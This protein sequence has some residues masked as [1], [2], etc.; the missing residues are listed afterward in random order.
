MSDTM[1]TF[2]DSYYVGAYWGPRKESPKECA[3]RTATFLNLLAQSDPF[4]SRWYKPTRSK[5]DAHQHPIMPPDLATLTE[6]FRSGVNREKGGPVF[7]DLGFS[8]WFGNG[9]TGA[10]SA[11][12]RIK[13]GDY[14]GATPN[15]C[16]LKL[17]RKGHNAD[18]LLTAPM[19]AA[20]LRMMEAAWAPDWAVATSTNFRDVL[21]EDG[22]TGTFVGW[23]TYL[24][25]HRGT[26]PPLPAP[27]R[28]EPVE[29]RG[30]LVILTPAHLT[31]SDP[32]HIAL[33]RRVSELLAR[34]GL[35]RPVL[36]C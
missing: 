18:R 15:S 2:A 30:A 25:R 36:T 23:A 6:L 28:V 24:S 10:D 5:K 14:C 34:A 8:F 29:D 33:A 19:M 31:A 7:E 3:E 17:P 9:G 32:E 35:L 11:E 22:S 12:L 26:V 4:L 16:V 1:E 21:S 13:C 20:L 27:V